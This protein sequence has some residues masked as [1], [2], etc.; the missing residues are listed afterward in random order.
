MGIEDEF[1]RIRRVREAVEGPLEK[2]RKQ[3]EMMD[4]L[5]Q[6][7][8]SVQRM[9]RQL[10]EASAPIRLAAQFEE[11]SRRSALSEATQALFVNSQLGAQLEAA[12]WQSELLH[13]TLRIAI[14]PELSSLAA[15]AEQMAA[16]I[17]PFQMALK[18]QSAWRERL[19]A[20]M[21][22]VTTPWLD[23]NFA[24]LSF[25]GFAVVS[26]LNQAVRYEAPYNDAAR[27]QIDCDLGDPIQIDDDA[28]PSERDEA[29]IQAGM[30]ASMLAI[31]P[32]A[33]GDV[34]IQ[35]GFVVR[36][37]FAPIPA[38]IDG[39]NPGHVFHPGHNF[40]IITVEQNLRAAISE[41]MRVQYGETWIGSRVAPELVES[42]ELRREAAVAQGERPLE[43]IQYSNFMELKDIVIR[44]QHWREV[45]EP[46][47]KKKHHF[48]T[49]MERLH[50]IRLPLAHSRPIGTAQQIHL[51]S[52][53]ACVLKALG[54]DIFEH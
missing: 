28:G 45:F 29:H 19:E 53:A 39:S 1:E 31:S 41:K 42:W 16:Q 51:I 2:L 36:A 34:L 24:S 9:L 35:T 47:F 30:N 21:A 27:E 37:E 6:P 4:R 32:A 20:Q 5:L 23:V 52:E 14:L 8:S 22:S 50:P 17:S 12:R 3:Q 44:K 49:S 7:E 18:T 25:E 26:R 48:E 11:M 43:L 33:M 46:I 13:E 10:D 40:L 54:V 38:T 15:M